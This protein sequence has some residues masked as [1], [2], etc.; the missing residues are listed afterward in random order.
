MVAGRPGRV[1]RA[2]ERADASPRAATSNVATLYG[3]GRHL[4]V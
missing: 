2:G 4:T 3:N 1:D